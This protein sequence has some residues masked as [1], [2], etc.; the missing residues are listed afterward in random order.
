MTLG[1]ACILTLLYTDLADCVL[2]LTAV[3]LALLNNLAKRR[4]CLHINSNGTKDDGT[5]FDKRAAALGVSSLRH[6]LYE[7]RL[8]ADK[9]DNLPTLYRVSTNFHLLQQ[10]HRSGKLL[11]ITSRI[12]L[13]F[14]PLPPTIST[15]NPVGTSKEKELMFAW[16]SGKGM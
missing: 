5:D 3:D 11:L 10:I 6:S 2:V 7:Y 8:R 12:S 1:Q 4:A 9:C 13:H 16:L 15:L 14:L